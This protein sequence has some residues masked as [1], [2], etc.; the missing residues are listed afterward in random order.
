MKWAALML[1]LLTAGGGFITLGLWLRHGGMREARE[2]GTA[3]A[4]P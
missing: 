1:W 2:T 3:S 4:H